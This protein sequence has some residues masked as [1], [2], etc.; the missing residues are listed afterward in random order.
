MF[1]QAT[2][3]NS[4]CLLCVY[5]A[6][7]SVPIRREDVN[8]LLSLSFCS[9]TKNHKNRVW[10]NEV[11]RTNKLGCR[12]GSG[13]FV[14]FRMFFAGSTSGYLQNKLLLFFTN[15]YNF[16]KLFFIFLYN[17]SLLLVPL[18]NCRIWIRFSTF[19]SRFKRK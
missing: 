5:A 11:N 12:F 19:G 10:R 17:N 4:V 9:F 8:S 15:I 3:V 6:V 16:L 13:P 14:G 1:R 18:S 7:H 2:I